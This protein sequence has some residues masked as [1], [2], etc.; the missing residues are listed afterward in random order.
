MGLAKSQKNDLAS[1]F[2]EGI[3]KIPSYQRRYSWEERQ[4]KDLYEDLEEARQKGIDHFLGTL[5]VQLSK[6]KGLE[7]VYNIIDGQQRLTTLLILFSVL[8]QKLEKNKQSKYIEAIKR[9]G[10]YFLEPINDGEKKFLKEILNV[11]TNKFKANTNSQELMQKAKKLYTV[12]TRDL[13][14]KEAEDFVDFILNK[15]LFL[16]NL[17]EEE[18]DAIRLFE[19]INARGLSLKYFD[20]IKSYFI[21]LLSRHN[22]ENN[23]LK[24]EN[25][26]RSFDGIYRFFDRKDLML[27]LNNDDKLLRYHFSSNP[28]LFKGWGYSMG[29]DEVFL[30]IKDNLT[31]IDKEKEQQLFILNYLKDIEE[32]IKA[33]YEIEKKIKNNER[34]RDFYL[35][36]DP[37]DRMYPFSIRLEIK[38]FLEGTITSLEKVEF[39]LKFRKNP[40]KDVFM[41]LKRIMGVD[42]DGILLKSSEGVKKAINELR[43]EQPSI[44]GVT[45]EHII[46]QEEWGAEVHIIQI[47]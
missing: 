20:K 26:E 23:S 39:Y 11:G 19:I 8:V 7:Y 45:A 16:I 5:S 25:V 30:K 27:G 4:Q 17:V 46:Y 9:D 37:G 36:L 18:S 24:R 43:K 41:I 22:K 40:K 35:Y 2:K 15:A 29:A 38:G 28:D 44:A 6:K 33:V 13:D 12:R 47:E 3:F 42:D 10:E 31:E 34:Y 14:L 21:F 1:L 32:Y